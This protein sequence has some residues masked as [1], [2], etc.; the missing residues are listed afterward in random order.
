MRASANVCE[1][2]YTIVRKLINLVAKAYSRARFEIKTI[3]KH[4][5]GDSLARTHIFALRILFSNSI[6]KSIVVKWNP[7]RRRVKINNKSVASLDSG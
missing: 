5:Q 7:N 6:D 3:R 1:S 4:F 2:V